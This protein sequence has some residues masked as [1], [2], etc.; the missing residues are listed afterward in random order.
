MFEKPPDE[1]EAAVSVM[2]VV[3]PTEVRLVLGQRCCEVR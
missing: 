1:K 3:A 2:P